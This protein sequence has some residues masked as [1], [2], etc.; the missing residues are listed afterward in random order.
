MYWW[1]TIFFS[2]DLYC[3]II[4]DCVFHAAAL[5]L[6][7]IRNMNEDFFSAHATNENSFTIEFI[8]IVNLQRQ[9]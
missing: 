1:K 7:Y 6:P 9:Y 3:I 5:I 4:G 8:D 2:I